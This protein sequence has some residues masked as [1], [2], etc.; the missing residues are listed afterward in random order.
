MLRHLTRCAAKERTP[1][2]SVDSQVCLTASSPPNWVYLTARYREAALGHTHHDL[3]SLI[4]NLGNTLGVLGEAQKKKELLERALSIQQAHFGTEH[5][6]VGYSAPLALCAIR[7]HS[8]PQVAAVIVNLANAHG[9]LGDIAKK[10]SMLQQALR[11]QEAATS[12]T[13]DSIRNMVSTLVN[14]GNACGDENDHIQK[15]ELLERALH[16]QEALMKDKAS[17][18]ASNELSN[19]LLNLGTAYGDLGD[20]SKQRDVLERTLRIKESQYGEDHF[21][22]AKTLTNLGIAYGNLKHLKE[23]QRTMMQRDLLERSLRIKERHYAADNY[24]M[25][26]TLAT[27]AQV[28]G[29]MKSFTK[30]RELFSRVLAVEEQHF[31]GNSKEVAQTLC[32]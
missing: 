27:L 2:T 7:S 9:A 11:I 18:S 17:A 26:S 10:R 6:E 5:I 22:L 31:G 29:A 14:L 19:I 4:V 23:G 24:E 15:K 30:Q 20:F 28:H 12:S 3:T 13:E 21:E 25:V 1:V 8:V 16:M 32:E